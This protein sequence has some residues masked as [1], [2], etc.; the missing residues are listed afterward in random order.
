VPFA[1][2]VLDRENEIAF[3]FKRY[4]IQAVWRGERA[5]RGR[6]KELRQAD[7][8]VIWND[9]NPGAIGKNLFY[10]SETLFV[11]LKTLEAIRTKFLPTKTLTMH[12]NNR[13]LLSG[14]FE[15][16]PDLDVA[17]MYSLVDK[18]YKI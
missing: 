6:F 8:D 5:Q 15:Q 17:K 16:F 9:A 12:I 1:R 4:Q 14:F 13:Y 18:Y 2:Y 3:P 7:I 11:I 10:D